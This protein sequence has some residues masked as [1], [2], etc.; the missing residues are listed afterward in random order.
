[1]A[2]SHS[3]RCP[4]HG[5]YYNP[6][7]ADGCAKCLEGP[8]ESAQGKS[9][10][11]F[12]LVSMV[13]WGVVLGAMG[14]GGYWAVSAMGERGGEIF[15]E[16][17]ATASRIDPALVR[18]EL[19]AV[20]ALVYAEPSSPFG[21]G[22]QIQRASMVL[23]SAVMRAATPLLGSRHGKKI[24]GF[25]SMASRTEDAGYTTIHMEQVRRDW[26]EIRAEV[27]LQADWFRSGGR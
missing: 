10:G 11:S 27:F 20:E 4:E 9:G 16:T 24:V 15:A 13:V 17:A 18:S 2:A 25:G 3:I 12:S 6:N 14:W 5:F 21:H 8:S 1:M 26:E 23:F 22:G 7:E 19:E